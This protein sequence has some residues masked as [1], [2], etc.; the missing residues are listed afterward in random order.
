[1]WKTKNAEEWRKCWNW[2]LWSKMCIFWTHSIPSNQFAVYVSGEFVWCTCSSTIFL[3]GINI[4][5]VMQ[6]CSPAKYR[7]VMSV[8]EFIVLSLSHLCCFAIK[9]GTY[10]PSWFSRFLNFPA[11]LTFYCMTL[12]A[13]LNQIFVWA[14]HLDG[15]PRGW[16]NSEVIKWLQCYL[17]IKVEKVVRKKIMCWAL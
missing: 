14:I 7:C 1:M 3:L 9:M 12:H 6:R 8:W 15:S 2:D 4:Q 16:T 11:D 5:S 13:I 10:C 17:S